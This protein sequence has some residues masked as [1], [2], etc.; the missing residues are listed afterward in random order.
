VVPFRLLAVNSLGRKSASTVNTKSYRN[1]YGW[2]E[3]S[4]YESVGI[5]PLFSAAFSIKKLTVVIIL[6]TIKYFIVI[7]LL[8]P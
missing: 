6:L 1:G 5:N 7:F 2:V 4:C 8:V 3:I